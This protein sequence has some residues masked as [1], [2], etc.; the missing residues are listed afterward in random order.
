MFY[1]NIVFR[2]KQRPP[3]PYLKV[4]IRLIRE[5]EIFESPKVG[6]IQKMTKKKLKF[7]HP[8][9]PVVWISQTASNSSCSC[10]AGFQV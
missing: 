3:K 7:L 1:Y 8:L 5:L 2:N 4:T 6:N 9:T 10:K